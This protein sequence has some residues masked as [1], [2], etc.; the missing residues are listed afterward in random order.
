MVINAVPPPNE[1]APLLESN[2][3]CPPLLT[4]TDEVAFAA[5]V[6]V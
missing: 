6:A 5:P 4:V 1:N 2:R 3:N